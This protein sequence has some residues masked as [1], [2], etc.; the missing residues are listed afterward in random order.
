MSYLVFC[1]IE[2]M[3]N[4]IYIY[5][6]WTPKVCKQRVF[7]AIL[8]CH[9]FTYLWGPGV[10]GRLQGVVEYSGVCST[11]GRHS[12]SVCLFACVARSFS[13]SVSLP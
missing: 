8:L 9:G 4:M 12:L 3:W 13:L 5:S 7:W 1:N 11:A 10:G 6:T 2:C